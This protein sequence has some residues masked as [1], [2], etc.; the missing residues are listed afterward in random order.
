MCEISTPDEG[1]ESVALKVF[2]IA[3]ASF[4]LGFSLCNVIYIFFSPYNKRNDCNSET[5]GTDKQ[6]ED[7]NNF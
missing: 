1:G 7:G 3:F 5:T 2:A 4:A 6:S